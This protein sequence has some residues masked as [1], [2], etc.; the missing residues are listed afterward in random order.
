MKVKVVLLLR[1]LS[2][3][4]SGVFSRPLIGEGRSRVFPLQFFREPQLVADGPPKQ[5]SLLLQIFI[6]L[7]RLV[8][9]APPEKP[10]HTHF[11]SLVLRFGDLS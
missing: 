4:V 3:L 8:G 11:K 1:R 5:A 9:E 7:G 2:Q 6:G 10:H